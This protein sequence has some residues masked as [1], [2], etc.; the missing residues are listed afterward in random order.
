MAQY[1]EKLLLARFRDLEYG[2]EHGKRPCFS[3]FLDPGEIAV[4]YRQYF[5]KLPYLLWG[6]YDDAERKILGIFPDF[7]EPTE[8]NFPLSALRIQCAEELGHRT[9]L[10]SVMGLGIERNLIGDVAKEEGHAVLFACNS[11][12]SYLEMNFTRAG[13]SHVKLQEVPIKELTLL[14]RAWE[15]V[16]GTVASLRLDCVLGVLLRSSRGKT[17]ELLKKELVSVNHVVCTKGSLLLKEEDV[18]SIRGFGR[19]QVLEIGGES[20]KGRLFI[21]LKKYI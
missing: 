11:I 16:T 9:V 6:G 2:A 7:V 18:L 4:F 5:P 12:A 19:A 14:P 10:G 3:R 21:T 15:P 1:D 20:R 13:K 17:E 8:E